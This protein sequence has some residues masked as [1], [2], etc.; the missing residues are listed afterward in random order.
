M[1]IKKTK[2]KRLLNDFFT[3][4][5]LTTI[6]AIEVVKKDDTLNPEISS[7]TFDSRDCTHGSLYFALNGLHTDGH[8]YINNAIQKG[9]AVIVHQ[10]KLETYKDNVVYIQVGD[11]RFAMSPLS[12]AFYSYPSKKMVV[13]GV[14]GTEGK[15]TT[16]YLIFQLLRF[17]GKKCGFISTVQYSVDGSEQ[18]NKEHQTTPEATIIQ[19]RLFQML[20]NGV[21]YAVVESSSHGLSAKTN[22]LGDVIFDVGI[23]TNVTH[24]HLE[25]HKTW[26]QY[27]SD[28]ANLFRAL[29]NQFHAKHQ[30]ELPVFGIVN[31]DDKSA[32][33]FVQSTKHKVY[34]VSCNAD[35]NDADFVI[36]NIKS[37][38]YGN[39]YDVFY[40]KSTDSNA[41]CDTGI[42]N[43]LH[44][45]DKL[46][47]AFNAANVLYSLIAVS[48]I[49]N[50]PMEELGEFVQKLVPVRGRMTAIDEGQPFEVI[51][52]YAHTPSSFETIFPPIKKRLAQGARIIS[53]FGSAGERDT[54]KRSQ[55]G[56]IAAKYSDIIILC[57]EDPRGEDSMA[58]LEDIAAGIET[59]INFSTHRS[60]SNGR[61]SIERGEKLFLI[62]DRE[63]AI[64]KSFELANKNDIVLLLGKGHENSI[65]YNSGAIKYDEIECAKTLLRS[66]P[67]IKKNR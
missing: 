30:S 27:R 37:T 25:F 19:R 35:N 21:R 66:L 49:L 6:G 29:D 58:I 24:E 54:A 63:S 4:D 67:D 18:M 26:E 31:A 62:P 57:D 42:E 45:E 46:P 47:G 2:M 50:V 40:S 10:Q 28:K 51:V 22:R 11:S 52:D 43:T 60:K 5:L 15:S 20:Q 16:V 7:L 34:K 17:L 61:T 8:K 44:I 13:F 39:T 12:A 56:E 65:I 59:H 14:T 38:A 3:T 53:L 41:N 48:R 9:A 36:R 32:D 33:Y 55:Q 64:K 1:L 23:M